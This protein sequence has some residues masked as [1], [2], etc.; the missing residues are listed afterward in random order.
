MV[1]RGNALLVN[2]QDFKVI[3]RCHT[4]PSEGVCPFC[5][6]GHSL[7]IPPHLKSD[8]SISVVDPVWCRIIPGE[9]DGGG[10]EG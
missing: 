4:E 2:G 3:T 10:S 5:G 9:S 8:D 1:V 7:F 6:I